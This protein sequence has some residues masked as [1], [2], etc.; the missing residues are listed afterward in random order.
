MARLCLW[1]KAFWTPWCR[2]ACCPSKGVAQSRAY[3]GRSGKAPPPLHPTTPPPWSMSRRPPCWL[4]PFRHRKQR[5]GSRLSRRCRHIPFSAA[6]GAQVP[7]G[8]APVAATQ[9]SAPA[10]SGLGHPPVAHLR[11]SRALPL[12]C[13][14]R[15][16]QAMPPAVSHPTVTGQ[17]AGGSVLGAAATGRRART[18]TRRHPAS[19][20]VNSGHCMNS[21]HRV[22][23][24][25]CMN[26]SHRVNSSQAPSPSNL[27]AC[28]ACH[29][30]MAGGKTCQA[31]AI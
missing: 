13:K 15:M 22:N 21:S 26:S 30:G 6:P 19:H 9:T 12:C 28:G 20:R 5:T 3:T 25:H 2:V 29:R 10:K 14:G 4:P 1:K 18:H 8:A 23:S 24:S 31:N 27:G 16:Q 11:N 17:K 7:S